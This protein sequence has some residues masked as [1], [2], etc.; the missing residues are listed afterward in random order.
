MKVIHTGFFSPAAE[1]VIRSFLLL[2]RIDNNK[3]AKTEIRRHIG[4]SDIERA[5]NGEICLAYNPEKRQNW[6]SS[7]NNFWEGYSDSEA[8]FKIGCFMKQRIQEVLNQVHREDAWSRLNTEVIPFTIAS[9]S[10]TISI[11]DYYY[12]YD[13]FLGR[14]GSRY[15]PSYINTIRGMAYDPVTS[16][17]IASIQEEIKN[18]QEKLKLDSQTL[19]REK[20]QV[21]DKASN[22]IK[23]EYKIKDEQLRK[24]ASTKIAELQMN[25]QEAIKSASNA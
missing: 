20:W 15:S 18:V 17:M 23:A 24:D 3:H 7:S 11:K 19:E 1:E 4:C 6:R 10:L 8:L 5:S 14:K 12:I 16:E 25:L 9:H 2:Q 21:I 13:S 22:S